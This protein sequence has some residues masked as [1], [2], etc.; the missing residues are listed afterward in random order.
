L[1]ERKRNFSLSSMD[2]AIDKVGEYRSPRLR[3]P[4]DKLGFGHARIDFFFVG[5][6]DGKPNL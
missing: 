5:I 2:N 1:K 6:P 4:D 3:V